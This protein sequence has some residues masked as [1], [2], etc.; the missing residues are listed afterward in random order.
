MGRIAHGKGRRDG[1]GIHR[2]AA[3]GHFE[4]RHVERLDLVAAMVVAATGAWLTHTAAAA[5][6]KG[7]IAPAA[8]AKPALTVTLT[9]AQ[10]SAISTRISANGN[11]AA[12]HAIVDGRNLYDP[13]KMATLG[14]T[15]RS[16]GRGRE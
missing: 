2:H 14:F 4:P 6:D 1:K 5:A 3:D 13:A 8:A 12:W 11:I 16:I 10:R 15:Y 7:E 9:Q